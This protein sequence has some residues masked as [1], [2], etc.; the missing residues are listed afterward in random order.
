MI[1]EVFEKKTNQTPLAVR[2]ANYFVA[3]FG[4]RCTGFK[5]AIL[6]SRTADFLTSSSWSLSSSANVLSFMKED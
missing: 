6:C 4:F 1:L 2:I 5:A 3:R